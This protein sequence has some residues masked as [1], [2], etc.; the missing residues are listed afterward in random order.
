MRHVVTCLVVALALPWAPAC[1]LRTHDRLELGVAAGG[2]EEGRREYLDSC[3]SCHGEHARGDGTLAGALK[4]PPSD[5][6]LLAERSGGVFPREFVIGML[7]GER[8]P[9][10]AHGT[11][12]MPVWR[13]RLNGTSGATGIAGIYEQR[14]LQLVTN[15][16]ESL[17]RP[18]AHE[19]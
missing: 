7:A 2:I 17:Q 6:T 1:T 5:L 12:E 3:A 11:R 9:P 8:E 13:R 19:Q 14:R 16:L 15:Y 18:R 4:T 10:V